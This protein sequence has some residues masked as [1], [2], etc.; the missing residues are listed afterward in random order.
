[1]VQLQDAWI[2]NGRQETQ[3]VDVPGWDEMCRCRLIDSEAV[4]INVSVNYLKDLELGGSRP[5]SQSG[6]SDTSRPSRVRVVGKRN[7]EIGL[8]GLD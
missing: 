1:M 6:D 5:L 4:S 8:A 7:S 3:T 2:A